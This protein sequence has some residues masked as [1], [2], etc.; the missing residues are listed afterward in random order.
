ML[1][2]LVVVL[3][4]GAG[5]FTGLNMMYGAVAGRTREIATLQAL[6]FR[7]RAI[8][9]SLIQEGMLLAAAASL[10]AGMVALFW[11]NGMAIRFTMG[12]FT[13]RIDSTA[14][15]VGCGTGLILG[16]VGA[17]PPA[18]RALRLPV[19]ESLKAV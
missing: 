13:L 18:I 11:V 19:V 8:L 7:R 4:A 17:I 3:V 10:L 2:W 6:G 1:A 12:A 15:L 9:V 5:V 16:M 14:L